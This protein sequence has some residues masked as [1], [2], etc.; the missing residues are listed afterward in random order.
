MGIAVFMAEATSV[1]VGAVFPIL[2][3][4]GAALIFFGFA[5]MGI[6]AFFWVVTML[7]ETNQRS[8]EEI[9]LDQLLNKQTDDSPL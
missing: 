6:L 7:P 1:L 9:E 5:A 4:H 3:K 8:L 2:L